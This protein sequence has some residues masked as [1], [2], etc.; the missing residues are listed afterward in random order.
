MALR[1]VVK[2]GD[3]ILRKKSRYV[4][5]V[6]DRILQLLDDMLE[7]MRENDGVGLAAPQVGVLK[8]ICVT[9]PDPDTGEFFE[10]IDPQITES[11]GEQEFYEGCLSI[12]GYV[13]KVKRPERIKVKTKNRS[14][15][16]EEKE[17][18]GFDAI[19]ACHEIDH[20]EGI[21]YTDKAEDVHKPG[22]RDAAE[23]NEDSGEK[24]PG[25]GE[26]S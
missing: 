26:R 3:D 22:E 20:L 4:D 16:W 5:K 6:D 15:D 18:E 9:E 11:E 10:L 7:T 21:L 19:V 12:P 8:R 2:E 25:K 23:D 1:N 13:G 17:F 14:G 24:K